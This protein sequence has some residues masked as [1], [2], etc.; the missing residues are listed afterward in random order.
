MDSDTSLTFLMS[1]MAAS[2]LCLSR[3][4]IITLAPLLDRSIAV[5]FPMP[6]LDPGETPLGRTHIDG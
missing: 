2:A 6:V 1:L 4:A 5:V 3:Q